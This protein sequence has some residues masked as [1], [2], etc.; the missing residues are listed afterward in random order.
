MLWSC[1]YS[2]WPNRQHWHVV[3]GAL[4]AQPWPH[5][6]DEATVRVSRGGLAGPTLREGLLTAER[7]LRRIARTCLRHING[8][9]TLEQ[10]CADMGEGTD[11]SVLDAFL[12][13]SC[14]PGR[15]EA[16]MSEHT[17]PGVLT[18]TR[19][20][21]CPGLEI[22]SPAS[23]TWVA[24]EALAAADDVL[25]FGGEQLETATGGRVRAARHRVAPPPE[26]CE[27]QERNSVVF[28]LRVPEGAL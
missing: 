3:C 25:V 21:D 14:P 11:P 10:A 2:Q 1:G 4:D 6:E 8:V 19:V 16:Q 24:V 27:G 9:G 26:R 23:A 28:E 17:D 13:A 12:Y 18:L 15:Q 7:V 5:D 22:L 20:S